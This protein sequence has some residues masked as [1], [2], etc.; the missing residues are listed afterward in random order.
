MGPGEMKAAVIIV[1]IWLWVIRI[2]PFLIVRIVLSLWL[3]LVITAF[4]QR[5]YT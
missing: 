5:L 4:V 1:L 2:V 3:T